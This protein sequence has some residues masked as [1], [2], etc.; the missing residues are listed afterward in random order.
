MMKKW[1]TMENGRL[2]FVTGLESKLGLMGA[3]FKVFGS[4]GSS[5][6][7]YLLGQTDP[8]IRVIGPSL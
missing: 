5:K 4:K 2:I 6:K 8:L 3:T 7:E 1:S